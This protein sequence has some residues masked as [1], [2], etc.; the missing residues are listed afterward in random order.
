VDDSSSRRR[1]Q[2]R[3]RQTHVVGRRRAS[4]RC[5]LVGWLAL[6][7]D[8]DEEDARATMG[9][10]A[11]ECSFDGGGA[12]WWSCVCDSRKQ[13]GRRRPVEARRDSTSQEG[14]HCPARVKCS[15]R[16][17]RAA[18]VRTRAPCATATRSL[19][20]AERV[21]LSLSLQPTTRE[22]RRAGTRARFSPVSLF[23]KQ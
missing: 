1:R 7:P 8:R 14:A 20:A 9:R 17:F 2:R 22:L 10:P 4:V 18:R 3:A 19:P 11:R 5:V 23:I 6:G 12:S 16:C 13:R 15:A 21:V